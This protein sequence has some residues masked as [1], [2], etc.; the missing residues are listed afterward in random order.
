[1]QWQDFPLCFCAFVLSVIV[2]TM[3]QPHL[4]KEVILIV[5]YAPAKELAHQV[6][7]EAKNLIGYVFLQ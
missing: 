1:M 4:E 5:M 7:L 2:H 6:Y 3:D